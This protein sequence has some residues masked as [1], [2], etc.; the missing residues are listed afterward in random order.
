MKYRY[1][2]LCPCPRCRMHG[3]TG[4]AFLITLGVLFLLDQMGRAY[5]MDFKFTWPAL[6][7]VMGLLKLLEHGASI[8][9]HIPRQFGPPAWQA[10]D[11][12]TGQPIPP[13]Y[14]GYSPQAPVATPPPS[15]S[16]AGFI[17]PTRP[18]PGPDDQGG[19]Q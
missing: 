4:P 11:P 2:Q 6:L 5:W 18:G 1:N 7:I 10:R 9:G 14:Q 3:Y 12:R 17:T 15:G 13:G 16:P 8:N 19:A